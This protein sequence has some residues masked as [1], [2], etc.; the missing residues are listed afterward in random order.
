MASLKNV[1]TIKTLF[2][3]IDET[4]TTKAPIHSIKMIMVTNYYNNV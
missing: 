3:V 2:Y 1:S 4:E